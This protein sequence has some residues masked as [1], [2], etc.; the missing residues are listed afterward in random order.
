V[1]GELG[2]LRFERNEGVPLAGHALVELDQHFVQA[3]TLGS[4]LDDRGDDVIHAPHGFAPE[5]GSVE[6][7]TLEVPAAVGPGGG[8]VVLQFVFTLD[9]APE[10]YGYTWFEVVLNAQ[11]HLPDPFWPVGVRVGFW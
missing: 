1:L 9:A 5:R 11:D 8:D 7:V 10:E 3:R 6:L 2:I 4:H